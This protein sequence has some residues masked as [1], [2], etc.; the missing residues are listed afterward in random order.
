MSPSTS[1]RMPVRIGNV[2]SRPAATAT[3]ATAV[4]EEIRRDRAGASRQIRQG[5]VVLG[6]QGQQVELGAATDQRDLGA[7]DDECRP[8]WAAG[9]C[10]CRRADLPE[11]STRPAVADVGG[12]LRSCAGLVVESGQRQAVVVGLDEHAGRALLP[13]GGPEGCVL[14]RRRP[15]REHHD[16]P[17]TSRG[18]ASN[19]SPSP[20]A[21]NF[22]RG[23]SGMLG[24]V[25]G[26]CTGRVL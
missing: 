8:A 18:T 25:L 9:T 3:W 6:R 1:I 2:S 24:R 15:R 7:V 11:T 4:R 20:A 19:P 13:A 5:R 23:Q 17:G 16:R 22:A 26:P 14:S 21:V 12:R 10:R